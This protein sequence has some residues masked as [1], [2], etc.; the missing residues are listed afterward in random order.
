MIKK[1]K[2]YLFLIA[3]LVLSMA[4]VV[5]ISVKAVGPAENDIGVLTELAKAVNADNEGFLL[6]ALGI[7]YPDA[8]L[9]GGAIHNVLESF[10]AGIAVNGTTI[11]DSSGNFDG[12]ITSSTGTFSSTLGVTGLT[13]LAGFN[14]SGGLTSTSS[15]NATAVLLAGDFDV[16]DTID[17]TSTN[18]STT[19][20]F[21]ATSTITVFL[22][23]AQDKG[24]LT[25]QNA[26][27]TGGIL[28]TIS[29]GAGFDFRIASSTASIILDDGDYAEFDCRRLV[30]T[31]IDCLVST[32]H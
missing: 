27:T 30:N 2:G 15:A 11:I 14:Y 16:E 12:A 10:D 17:F 13:S 1:N 9:V 26:T 20:T 22:P 18:Q 5:T 21:P 32:Y 25:F 8:G 28:N 6:K 31:D 7:L 4:L 29:A 23:N 3:G 19:I 24:I